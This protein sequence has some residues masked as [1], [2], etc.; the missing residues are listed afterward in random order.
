MILE[1]VLCLETLKGLALLH[2]KCHFSRNISV[3]QL[4]CISV[5]NILTKCANSRIS[6]ES[7]YTMP[8]SN[9][10]RTGQLPFDGKAEKVKSLLASKT[11]C[12]SLS[13]TLPSGAWFSSFG[14]LFSGW[15]DC[16]T[17]SAPFF[18]SPDSF[19]SFNCS[20]SSDFSVS[21]RPSLVIGM[22][23]VL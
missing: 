7:G 3:D 23:T 10:V 22:L 17:S 6:L 15:N 5:E 12:Q 16:D 14:L 2:F 1:F 21:S 4:K 18:S 9:Q 19:L 8:K 13:Y 20:A 11:T